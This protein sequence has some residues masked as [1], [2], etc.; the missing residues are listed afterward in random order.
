[1]SSAHQSIRDIEVINAPWN[2]EVTL[3]EVEYEGGFKMVRVRIKEGKRFTDLEL[4]SA[5]A[6]AIAGHLSQWARENVA[7]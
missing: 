4:D 3:Q 2:K 1:M 5:T 6:D 7:P